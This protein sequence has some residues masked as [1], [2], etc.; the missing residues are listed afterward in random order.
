MIKNAVEFAALKKLKKMAP[1]EEHITP[2]RKK[3]PH[4][5]CVLF[6]GRG[7]LSSDQMPPKGYGFLVSET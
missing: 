3:L 7:G 1:R 4:Q 5:K 6:T 2:I